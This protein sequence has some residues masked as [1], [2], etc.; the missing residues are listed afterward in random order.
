MNRQRPQPPAPTEWNRE[1]FE[2]R[3]AAPI[4]ITRLMRR[5][6]EQLDDG[7][8][9]IA[10]V[11]DALFASTELPNP[12]AIDGRL[13]SLIATQAAPALNSVLLHR[14]LQGLASKVL[15][16][17]TKAKIHARMTKSKEKH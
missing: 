6:D 14:K 13:A 17:E 5:L 7:T 12:A 4:T 11:G 10:D 1:P 15:P 8:I 3:P 2:L 9:V 16:D